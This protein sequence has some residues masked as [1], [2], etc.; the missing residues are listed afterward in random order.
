MRVLRS[1]L[2]RQIEILSITGVLCLLLMAATLHLQQLPKNVPTVLTIAAV[3]IVTFLFS[4]FIRS[5]VDVELSAEVAQLL[6][7]SGII[8]SLF[9]SWIL[10]LYLKDMLPEEGIQHHVVTLGGVCMAVYLGIRCLD[11]KWLPSEAE[12][13]DFDRSRH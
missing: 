8:L 2:L 10:S 5:K 6:Y 12:I 9:M 3:L 1:F 11:I 7:P 13:A 4:R